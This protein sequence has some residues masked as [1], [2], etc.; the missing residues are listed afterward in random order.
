MNKTILILLS[1]LTSCQL[2]IG[3]KYNVYKSSIDTSFVSTNLGYEKKISIVLPED[4]QEDIIKE[5]PLIL[6]F[7]RQN[8][9]SYNHILHTIDYLTAAEQMP[10]SIVIGVESDNDKR[11]NEARSPHSH[12]N[13][14][15]HLTEK[16]LFDELIPFVESKFRASKFRILIG[17]SW[18][19]HFTTA[20]FASNAVNLNAVISLDPFY[21]AGPVS[22]TDSISS[23]SNSKFKQ[24]K[25][26]RFAIGKD[27]PEDLVN[28]KAIADKNTNP[29]L[30]IQGK[31]Y[32]MA[33]HNAV[34]GLGIGEALYDIFEYWSIQ[35]LDFF[36]PANK[37]VDI[38][39][40]LQHNILS[41][42]GSNL[43]FSLGI[44][45]GK[46]WGFYNE[47]AYAKAIESWENMLL[48]YPNFSEGYLYIID[49]K[50]KLNMD[51]MLIEKK[52]KESLEKSIY[53]S[54]SDKKELLNEL[55][56]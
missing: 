54:E 28:I 8:E 12:K 24:K 20:M 13:G 2:I 52:F 15:A 5:Y 42:Y 22:L 45:N 3:Q 9:R 1:I 27:Y 48:Q 37:R 40:N 55:K 17:H 47:G 31:E 25:Y 29:N 51:T 41:H 30:D 49:A 36:K 35:Q 50:Q 16:Y 4:W 14:K 11:I 18:Y 21:T 32:P 23:L 10:C 26:Y 46:G 33:F 44:L 43:N 39:A 38:I 34:P 6:I 19:G 53:Y 56:K 7:D